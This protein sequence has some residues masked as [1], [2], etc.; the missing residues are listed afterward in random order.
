MA[1]SLVVVLCL[2]IARR[3]GVVAF[4]ADGLVV[5]Y[6]DAPRIEWSV[7]TNGSRWDW[8]PWPGD[9]CDVLIDKYSATASCSW[10]LGIQYVGSVAVA[11]V[12]EKP[13]VYEKNDVILEASRLVIQGED[14]REG[15]RFLFAPRVTNDVSVVTQPPSYAVASTGSRWR[16]GI[17]GPLRVTGV[18]AGG[19]LVPVDVV[20]GNAQSS[21]RFASIIIESS[22]R[23][24]AHESLLSIRGVNM[25]S[26]SEF[27]F[28]DTDLSLGLNYT[29]AAPRNYSVATL[30][31]MS[32]T[33]SNRQRDLRVLAVKFHDAIFP[34]SAKGI[35][36]ASVYLEPTVVESRALRFQSEAVTIRGYFGD[37]ISVTFDPPEAECVMTTVNA[38]HLSCGRL[39]SA[40]P[41]AVSV[42][43][44]D[45]GA[46][47]KRL[48]VQVAT[49]VSDEAR[50]KIL[51]SPA[52]Q[53]YESSTAAFLTI[54]G[55]GF[56][57]AKSVFGG[58]GDFVFEFDPPIRTTLIQTNR[59]N[60]TLRVDSEPGFRETGDNALRLVSVSSAEGRRLDD[61]R[62]PTVVATVR[63]N[64]KILHPLTLFD[65][66]SPKR[67]DVVIDDLFDDISSATF[68]PAD[69]PVEIDGGMLALDAQSWGQDV[70]LKI[71]SL[72]TTRGGVVTLG[73]PQTLARIFSDERAPYCRRS[74]ECD[75]KTRCVCRSKTMTLITA[76]PQLGA[77]LV[78]VAILFFVVLKMAQAER[79]R[80][81]EQYGRV[82]VSEIRQSSAWRP[83]WRRRRRAAFSDARQH[84]S[85]SV[86]Y[87]PVKLH[88]DDLRHDL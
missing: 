19:G 4:D 53:L 59:R 54:N 73:E 44:I 88:D 57:Q 33:W 5:V 41:G 79:K 40:R 8:R 35:K 76:S 27:Y 20:V 51:P 64:P 85:R 75:N 18:D 30:K 15:T 87:K 71:V 21:G 32:G 37:F 62:R 10:R 55:S 49:L 86:G 66:L 58:G 6:P 72:T 12:V 11:R 69:F 24:Y 23:I 43:S 39:V 83:T 3:S 67:V 9:G 48:N 56:Q 28:A 7:A 16:G 25:T 82:A 38:T 45:A 84:S 2:L 31:L 14:L 13:V 1:V 34:V 47:P 68:D 63:N 61:Q 52:Q 81:T 60:V 74:S 17:P 77:A 78:L 50:I 29:L 70:D 26:V 65:T 80:R 46:G 22:E 36:V 42:D